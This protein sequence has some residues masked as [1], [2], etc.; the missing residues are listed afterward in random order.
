MSVRNLEYLFKPR[1]IALIG[2]SDKPGSVGGVLT[3][4]LMS[5]GFNGPII[6]VTPAHAVVA[7]IAAFRDVDSLPQAPELAVIATPPP[8]VPGLIAAL[9]RRGTKA[10]VVITAGFGEGG[11]AA[12]VSLRQAMLDAAKPH[13]LRIV[14]PNCLGVMAPAHRLNATFAHLDAPRGDLAFVAQSGAIITAMLD[15]AAARGIGFSHVVSLGDMSDVDFGDMLDYLASDPRTR[16]ILLYIEG[17]TA[18]RKFMSAARV[19]ARTKPVLVVKAGRRREG[20]RAARSHTGALAGSDAVYDTAF[21]RAGMLRVY[22]LDELFDA[23]ETLALCDPVAGDRLAI[24]SNGGGLA[25]MAT[26]SLVEAGGRLAELK[27]ETIAALDHVLPHTWSHGNPI[28]IIGDASPQR[29]RDAIAIAR[30]DTNTD[31]LLVLNA[32]TALASPAEAA[33]AVTEE[34]RVKPRNL[35][36]SWVGESTADE[37]RRLFAAAGMPT[38]ATPS[39]AVRGFMHLVRHRRNQELLLQ[40]PAAAADD[41][42]PDR[43]PV[44]RLIDLALTQKRLW[45]TAAESKEVLQAYRIPVVVTRTAKNPDEVGAIVRA[46]GAPCAVKI[47]SPDITHKSDVGGVALDLRTPEAASAEAGLMLARIRQA[48]PNARI[49]GFTVEPMVVR[50]DAYELILGM[51]EDAQFGPIILFGHG[52]TAAEIIDDKALALAPLNLAL[53]RALMARTRVN[54]LLQGYRNQPPAALDAIGMTLVKL[55]QLVVDFAEIA[56][57][58]INP[59]LA[60]AKG[61]IAIDARIL[62]KPASGDPAA[63]LAIRPYPSNLV[64][65]VAL[66]D[67]RAYQLRPIRPEDAPA[68]VAL[69]RH[70][71]P[72]DVRMRFFAPLTELSPTLLA[73]LTQ[74]DYDREMA[75]LLYD[76]AAEGSTPEIVG[77]VRIAADP[78]NDQAEFAVVVR[79]DRKGHGIGYFLM[80]RI[81]AYARGRG[82][83]SLRGDVLRENRLMLE[84][85]RDL[86]FALCPLPEDA[87]IVRVTLDLA[88]VSAHV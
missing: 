73:R 5:G 62:V 87:E 52:G 68:I 3:H 44:R 12:G 7:G 27:P 75:L 15:W 37:A 80:T 60:D 45:L 69:F 42:A 10:A 86:G 84:L 30:R 59:L 25:V 56:E 36:T 39:E 51:T 32:P 65:R 61:V 58:D 17:V 8:T 11:D 50:R 21:R 66:S 34:G 9:G 54:R 20:A 23:A 77:V 71:E 41:F 70:L 28:D 72:E 40:V 14:G 81:I 2:A 47:L 64:E 48:L 22:E 88:A 43:D 1:S 24:L 85:C 6:P 53:A 16:A 82:I 63:R 76:V 74:L 33:R 29:Y 55:S 38:Y 31:A 46:L 79:S 35:L 19:A 67:G 18:P 26:D 83:R 13:L 57:L 4:N 78:D 49:E